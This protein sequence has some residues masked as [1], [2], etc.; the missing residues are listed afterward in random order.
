MSAEYALIILPPLCWVLFA[1]G[2]TGFKWLRRFVLPGVLGLAG[3]IYGKEILACLSVLALSCLV[4]C[5]S[6]G[7]GKSWL[8]RAV[9]AVSYSAVLLPYGFT[10]WNII[11]PIVFFGLFWLSNQKWAE[12]I[13]VWKIVEGTAG[14]L[15]GLTTAMTF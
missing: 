6:Y 7:E 13:V 11:F 10:A 5:L 12:K 15:M 3:F 1:L 8:Y 2:G 9:I 4:L 14:L